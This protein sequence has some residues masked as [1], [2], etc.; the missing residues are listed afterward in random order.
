MSTEEDAGKELGEVQEAPPEEAGPKVIPL[1]EVTGLDEVFDFELPVGSF[2]IANNYYRQVELKPLGGKVRKKIG[3][4]DI[5]NNPGKLVT[6]LLFELIEFPHFEY[7]DKKA[8]KKLMV[9]S[10][11]SA[12]RSACVMAIRKATKGSVPIIQKTECPG[13]PA[14]LTLS[15]LPEEVII[16][17]VEDTEYEVNEAKSDVIFPLQIGEGEKGKLVEFTLCRGFSEEAMTREQLRN[18]G[19]QTYSILAECTRSYDGKQVDE[20]FYSDRLPVAISDILVDEF[21]GNQP[22]PD[23]FLSAKCT[24]CGTKFDYAVEPSDFLLPSVRTRQ[25]RKRSKKSGR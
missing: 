23:T 19:E 1:P 16:V 12:D 11:F 7:H 17:R 14:E 21:T 18:L 20:Q 15:T 4:P 8:E 10:M 2:D 13:C 22:G 24:E 6:A 3:R 5:F 9:R 25:S